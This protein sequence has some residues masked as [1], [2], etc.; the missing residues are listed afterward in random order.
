[1]W[2]QIYIFIPWQKG[3][4]VSGHS[5][6]KGN[7]KSSHVFPLSLTQLGRQSGWGGRRLGVVGQDIKGIED[8]RWV[9]TKI[10]MIYPGNTEF[11]GLQKALQFISCKNC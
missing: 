6:K 3:H 11:S 5:K 8:N 10:K 4:L 1:M 2:R 9:I 7:V